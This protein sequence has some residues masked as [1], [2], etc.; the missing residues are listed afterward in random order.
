VMRVPPPVPPTFSAS[1]GP[2]TDLAAV[3]SV[4]DADDR[5]VLGET[6]MS[7]EQLETFLR[8]PAID[9]DRDILTVHDAD[10]RVIAGAA[11]ELR[12]PGVS[13]MTFGWVHP[14]AYGLGLGQAIVDWGV[15]NARSLVDE[16][17]DG[18]LV[19]HVMPVNVKNARAIRLAERNGFTPSRYFLEMAT[20]L[21]DDIEV[22]QL[23]EG[24][25]LRTMHPDEGIARLSAALDDAFRDHFGHVD[26]PIENVIARMENFRASAMWDDSLVW[27][28][29][30][31]G[32][33]AGFCVCIRSRGAN[34]KEGYVGS[35][36][37]RRP[38]RKRGLARFLLTNAFAEYQRRG[39]ESVALDVD[40][41][42]PTGATRLYESVGMSE[43][44]RTLDYSLTIRDGKDLA[45]R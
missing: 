10:G 16:A 7:L 1:L 43:V 44:S 26:A 6:S 13:S 5:E 36:G 45:V 22:A 39:Y 15:A 37:V 33:I 8:S 38:W 30:D 3:L 17:P 28:A 41:D 24:L 42:S 9:P 32:E 20:Q 23:T 19:E 40:A 31:A 34:P 18:A 21:G 35:L 29:E 14:D 2:P 25:S 4:I 11:F 12:Q 27:L